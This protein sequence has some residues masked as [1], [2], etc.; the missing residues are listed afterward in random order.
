MSIDAGYLKHLYA[1]VESRKGVAAD[2]SYIASL[3]RKG[4]KKIA[5]KLGEEAVETA[6]AATADDRI[7]IINESADMIFHWLILLADAGITP[8]EVFAEMQ[9]REGVSGLTEKANR[10]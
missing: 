5:Q 6:I 1:I 7:E 4:R 10:K 8:E 9:R 2:E 3:Y